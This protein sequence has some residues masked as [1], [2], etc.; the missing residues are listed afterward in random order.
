MASARPQQGEN[1]PSA[2]LEIVLSFCCYA[3]A[4]YVSNPLHVIRTRVSAGVWPARGA[5]SLGSLARLRAEQQLWAG[6]APNTL[7]MAVSA[8][9]RL[10][11]FPTVRT[12]MQGGGSH[13]GAPP[14]T[15]ATVAAAAACG[16][17]AGAV[18]SPLAALKSLLHAGGASLPPPGAS[19]SQQLRHGTALL[20]TAAR[21]MTRLEVSTMVWRGAFLNSVQ[22]T[23]L[24]IPTAWALDQLRQQQEGQQAVSTAQ[25]LGAYAFAATISGGE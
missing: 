12:W 21:R 19:S 25:Q 17:V 13:A 7:Q 20:L 6:A 5:V 24:A 16:A 23:S 9:I 22:I 2:G 14:S 3:V 1:R 4:S 10:G 11:M 8:S 15:A 18:I